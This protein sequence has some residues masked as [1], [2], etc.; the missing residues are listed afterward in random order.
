MILRVRKKYLATSFKTMKSCILFKKIKLYRLSGVV[1]QK[2][3]LLLHHYCNVACFSVLK[4]FVIVPRIASQ[5]H[6]VLGRWEWLGISGSTDFCGCV[7]NLVAL[8][9]KDVVMLK[10]AWL[11]TTLRLHFMKSRWFGSSMCVQFTLKIYHF[12]EGGGV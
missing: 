5:G 12:G 1:I 4:L 7:Q 8:T 6:W 10:A 2:V 11:S 9:L 3:Q